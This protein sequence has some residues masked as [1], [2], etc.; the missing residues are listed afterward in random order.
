MCQTP[1][2]SSYPLGEVNEGVGWGGGG[3]QWEQVEREEG[4]LWLKCEI[5]KK[6][7]NTV[8]I[9]LCSLNFSAIF[10]DTHLGNVLWLQ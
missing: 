7:S 2:G 8:M 6:F 5:K 3:S 10:L 1:P 4:E 9:I